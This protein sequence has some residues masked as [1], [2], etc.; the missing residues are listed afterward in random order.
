MR[1]LKPAVVLNLHT[2]HTTHRMKATS[3]ALLLI[4]TSAA[5]QAASFFVSESNGNDEQDGRRPESAWRSLAKVS[6]RE[7]AP[8]DRIHLKRGDH[9]TI[10]A[11]LML[12]GS[13]APAD[14][15]I[16]LTGYGNGNAPHITARNV[17]A[18]R[19]ENIS[20]WIIRGLTLELAD[21]IPI[22]A[23]KSDHDAPVGIY[24]VTNGN[25]G[26]QR[27]I[28]IENNEIFC[29]EGYMTNTGGIRFRV[30]TPDATSRALLLEN[31]RVSGNNLH[32]LGFFGLRCMATSEY[33]GSI[34]NMR[35][36]RNKLSHLAIQGAVM[37]CVDGGQISENE[38]N[39]GGQYRGS[40]QK[41]SAAG[42]WCIKS[43]DI[44]ID[45]NEAH[46]MSNW[47][48]LDGS[49]IHVDWGC[50]DIRVSHNYSHDNF[51]A[52]ILILSANKVEIVD[53]KVENND[54]GSTT[55]QGQIALTGWSGKKNKIT[56]GLKH[57]QIRNNDI[58]VRDQAFTGIKTSEG[59]PY[60][61]WANIDIVDNTIHLL[62]PE[63]RAFE[64]DQ[65]VLDEVSNNHILPYGSQFQ[66]SNRDGA[67]PGR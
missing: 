3:I 22:D 7:F 16:V 12:K 59:S 58:Y 30:E 54:L 37:E 24:I 2:L 15:R 42:L 31:V 5:S 62:A 32:H 63:A 55:K 27:D 20:H 33:P 28:S 10:E 21:T 36:N 52:G 48:D 51:G 67:V 13:G 9:W 1:L 29:R 66:N 17:D 65:S 39:R 14:A 60:S 35:W 57:V 45:G 53:N 49:G 23:G 40:K 6:E 56:K 38:L 44:L 43:R 8:G 41:W 26:T 34:R 11:P 64:V 4:A 18:V 19:A 50:E 47:L 61:E 25:N 46:H